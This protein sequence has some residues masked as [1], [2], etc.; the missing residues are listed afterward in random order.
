MQ[1][2]SMPSM[3]APAFLDH[4]V[5][6][7]IRD[8]HA[9]PVFV[10]SEEVLKQR[11]RAAL[12]FPNPYGLTV[13]Y[14][15]KAC[16]NAAVLKL[17]SGLGVCFDC[18]SGYEVQRAICAGIPAEKLSLSTQDLPTPNAKFQE[19]IDLG[20]KFNACSLHQLETF[21]RLYAG[22][23]CGIRFNPGTGS[24]GNTKTNVGGPSS[25]FGIWHELQ[26]KVKEIVETHSLTISRIHTHIGSGSD[27]KI[28][29]AV[30]AMSLA[31][32][33]AFPDATTI[34]LGGGFKVGRMMHERDN[35][36]SSLQAVGAPVKA[37]LEEFADKN[38][39]QLQ[40]EI[41][42][43]TFL[44]AN[45]G[46]LLS[47]VQDMTTT[48]NTNTDTGA[49]SGHEFLKLDCGMTEVLRPSLYGA[50]HPIISVVD[51]ATYRGETKDY[52]VVGHCCES[53]DLFSCKPGNS[54]ELQARTLAKTS[55]G[56][57]V[58]IEGSGAYCSSMC[59]KNYN[60]FPE[61]PEVLLSGGDRIQLMRRR[62]SLEQI[63]SNEVEV[64]LN[65]N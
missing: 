15:M 35:D 43:G 7:K 10:Y 29:H 53:G 37:A 17:F 24:G 50:Q 44:L 47:T 12:A 25:S 38:G 54:D 5:A 2:A 21:G 18:S 13:R 9:T 34:N 16:P 60:S 56:D 65:L 1:A 45:S 32:V 11:A 14:A 39:R 64:E 28:W 33:D 4:A 41:E 61:A 36:S 27:P 31:L 49:S 55:I 51:P 22:S 6:S 42:P 8:N 23:S 46:V 59:T 20:I 62:Q 58:V 26:G 63:I 52:V 40:L 3:E 30:T 19:L 48:T 57:M